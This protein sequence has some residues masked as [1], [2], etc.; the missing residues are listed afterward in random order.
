MFFKIVFSRRIFLLCRLDHCNFLN[1]YVKLV[2]SMNEN[3][4]ETQVTE[5]K[6]Q[7]PSEENPQ[8]PALK[9]TSPAG[10]TPPPP[11]PPAVATMEPA[12]TPPPVPEQLPRKSNK[13]LW[14][15]VG[16]L[17]LS[18]VGIVAYE[19][20]NRGFL[21]KKT[22]CTEEV[23]ICPDGTAVGRVGPNCEFA[24]CPTPQLT[25]VPIPEES[26]LASPSGT[27][28]ATPSA[29]PISSPTA[30]PRF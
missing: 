2:L 21:S 17:V 29:E 26:P 22:A 30:S 1:L 14:F 16:F 11:E 6:T 12:M 8:A 13:I 19:M 25:P 7:I 3:T 28:T 27:L 15:A 24:P 9:Q 10:P 23:M 20:I 4:G 18:I 5:Q